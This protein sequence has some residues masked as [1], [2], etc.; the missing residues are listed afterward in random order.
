MSK[1]PLAVSYWLLDFNKKTKKPADWWASFVFYNLLDRRQVYLSLTLTH[2][3]LFI[4]T[5]A[6]IFAS[7][8]ALAGLRSVIIF[9]Q[10]NIRTD[11]P[12]F[13]SHVLLLFARRIRKIRRL[14]CVAL[15]AAVGR[16]FS[17]RMA[18]ASLRC[19]IFCDFCGVCVRPQ[20]LI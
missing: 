4:N 9:G 5:I 16:L 19:V 15:L 2:G 10:K 18:H 1:R 3:R 20:K 11:I 13:F 8:C 6:Q 14:G 12:C 7:R 17:S